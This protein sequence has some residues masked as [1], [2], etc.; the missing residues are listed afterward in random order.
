MTANRVP[1]DVVVMYLRVT[2][3]PVEIFLFLEMTVIVIRVSVE[4]HLF[5]TAGLTVMAAC[6]VEYPVVP[7]SY[8]TSRRQPDC[9]NCT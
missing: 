5:E 9:E 7:I 3:V 2:R 1:R 8:P 4:I 6:S